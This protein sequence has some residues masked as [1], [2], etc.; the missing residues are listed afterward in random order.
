MTVIEL[1]LPE[2]INRSLSEISTKKSQ[3]ILDALTDH[4]R[5]VDKSR[6]IKETSS[7]PSEVVEQSEEVLETH[8][9]L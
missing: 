8:L 6:I 2:E 9:L 5:T 7:L 4:I 1:P 3:F